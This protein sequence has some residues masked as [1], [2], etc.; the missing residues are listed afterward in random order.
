MKHGGNDESNCHSIAVVGEITSQA[1]IR[2]NITCIGQRHVQLQKATRNATST[3]YLLII[4][5]N[6]SMCVLGEAVG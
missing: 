5:I 3:S 1:Y 4:R 6:K 2:C